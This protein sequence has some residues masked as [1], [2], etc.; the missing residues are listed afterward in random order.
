MIIDRTFRDPVLDAAVA[1]VRD[2]HLRAAT[3]VLAECRDQPELRALRAEVLSDELIGQAQKIAASATENEDPDLALLAGRAFIAEAWAVRGG[4]WATSVGE[5]RFKVFHSTLRRAVQPLHEAAA[6]LPHDPAPWANL[7]AVGMGLQVDREQI[8]KIWR[9]VTDRCG[10]FYPAHWY[11]VQIR[12]AK[13]HGSDAEMLAFAR[14]R[15]ARAPMGHPLAAMVPLAHFEIFLSRRQ[16]AAQRH[17][18]RAAAR[19]GGKYFGE[20]HGEIADASDRWLV[21]PRPHPRSLQA[22][23]LFAAAFCLAGDAARAHTHLRGMGDRL[24]SVPWGYLGENAAAEYQRV[25]EQYH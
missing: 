13:W 7:L 23:N 8:D 6:L 11:S 21:E 4:G 1:E 14:E 16:E 20:V 22:H 17:D 19:L 9:E 3:T 12:A 18:R 5:D 10:T 15:V 2:G 24:H 25:A